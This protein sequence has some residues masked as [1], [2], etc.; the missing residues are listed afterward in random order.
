MHYFRFLLFTM[1]LCPWLTWASPPPT[2]AAQLDSASAAAAFLARAD[3]L[4]AHSRLMDLESQVLQ[5]VADEPLKLGALGEAILAI[6]P[7]S[8][9]GHYALK[10][11][12]GHV[13]A[14]ETYNRHTENLLEIQNQMLSQGNGSQTSPYPIMTIYDGQTYALSRGETTVG[15]MYQRTE[16]TN[17]GYLLAAQPSKGA[18]TYYSFNLAELLDRYNAAQ[19]EPPEGNN[20]WRL[21]R[22]AATDMDSAAQ[23]A[24]GAYLARIEQY[25]QAI[26]WLRVGARPGNILANTILARVYHTQ[27]S[28]TQDASEKAQFK[29]LALD[30][31]MQAI[32][33]GSTE[34]MYTL[35]NLYL[36]DYYGE[37][38]RGAGIPLLQQAGELGHAESLIYL[39]HLFSIGK[40][41]EQDITQAGLYFEQAAKQENPDAILNYGRF[42]FTS[43]EPPA[44][45]HLFEWL[46]RLA[47]KK[48]PEAMIILGNLYA[49]GVGVT[50]STRK[51]VSW[52]KKA[53]RQA[54][55]DAD[56]INEVAWTLTVSD[57]DGLK[58]VK[59]ARRIMDKLMKN[60]PDAA[61]RPEYLDTWAAAYAANGQNDKAIELQQQA[62]EVAKEQARDDVL[63]ILELHMDQFKSGE[64]IT[65]PAP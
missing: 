18:L 14:T 1:A 2:T 60:V 24:I 7:A 54:P 61:G 19:E 33:L 42:V 38:N 37:E 65:E 47:R 35:A 57:V 30:N 13:E 55:D 46:D 4:E 62:I 10:T 28:G 48:N 21:I 11:F 6:Y 58:R 51:A 64:T 25:K 45:Q 50:S 63:D 3:F 53:A 40:E 56:I 26:G 20:P 43:R 8:Q 5:L 32:A 59:F 36:G 17:L 29:D 16:A 44:N 39:G 27:S 9:T 12:Y 34:S 41:V 15:A 31:H 23:T 22:E 49:R 52:Y